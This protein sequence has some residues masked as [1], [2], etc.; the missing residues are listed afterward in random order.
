M[1]MVDLI[2]SL[3]ARFFI[4]EIKVIGRQSRSREK[5]FSYHR[6]F[7][8]RIIGQIMSLEVSIQANLPDYRNA[9]QQAEARLRAINIRASR[10]LLRIAK[11]VVHVQS[12]RLREGLIVQGP[13]DIGSGTL[14]SEISAPSV[15]YA[16]IEAARGSDHDYPARTLLAGEGVIRQAEQDMEAAIVAV[17]EGR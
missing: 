4:G 14:E 13:F 11:Q 16:T 6:A 1:P 3:F 5:Y 10:Q 2:R 8:G 17:M 9:E 7:C 12:G 15:P